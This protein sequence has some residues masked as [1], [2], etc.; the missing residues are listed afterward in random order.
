MFKSIAIMDIICSI[1]PI[2][3]LITL[4]GVFK[5]SGTKSSIISLVTTIAISKVLYDIETTTIGEIFLSS[6]IKAFATIISV[7]WMAV[8][9]YNILLHSKHIEVIKAQLSNISNDKSI[10]V[11]LITWGFGSLLEGMAGY[12]TSVAIPAAILVTLGFKP[13]FT[14]VVS[15][16]ANSETTTFGAMGIAEIVLHNETGLPLQELCKATM[17][18]LAPFVIIIPIT[19]AIMADR[20]RQSLM[21]NIS[22]GI[23]IG[24]ASLTVQYFTATYL[25]PEMPAIA[26]GLISIIIIIIWCKHIK[27]PE[28]RQHTN[29]SSKDTWRAW[30]VYALIIAFIAISIPFNFKATSLILLAGASIGGIIQKVSIGTQFNILLK[31]LL[32][33]KGT[34]IMIISLVCLS[35]LMETTGM[36]RILSSSLSEV[37]ARMYSF[38]SPL[39][40]EIG[41]FLTGSGTT[42]NILLA[43]LQTA[44]SSELNVDQVWIATANT[45]GTTAGKII[46]PQSIAIAATAC[47]LQGKEG[48]ILKKTM[49]FAIAYGLILGLFVS[50]T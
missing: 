18:Q 25:G 32:Q 43:R 47:G 20:R 22:L 2:I 26:T 8:F 14:V 49:P 44:I 21:K 23:T 38:Y 7:V 9:S 40:G 36:V 29:L 24:I 41:T 13:M 39:I 19:L 42:A 31:T 16:I 3:L 37:T 27:Q 6:S 33:I 48:V 50:F 45:S 46:S 35:S 17:L 34:A 30:S 15:L 12:G 4:M 11:L 28:K 1:T 10:Q 5:V